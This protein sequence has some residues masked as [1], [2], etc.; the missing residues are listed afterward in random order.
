MLITI[1]RTNFPLVVVEDAGVEVHLL[2]VTKIQFQDFVEAPTLV[3]QERYQEML[4]L[5]PE[6][7]A[8]TFT[9]NNREQLFATGVLP[10]E[11]LAFARWLGQGFDLPT[12]QEWRDILAALRRVPPPRHNL[13]VD[14]V[15]GPAHTILARLKEQMHIRSMADFSLMRGGLVEWVRRTDQLVGLGVPRP[16]FHPNLWDPLVNE[17]KPIHLE[18]RVR[19]FGFRLVRRGDWYLTN[20]EKARYVF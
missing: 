17:I 18:E 3:N 19:Y 14:M 2:P 8:A 11:A 16:Q 4:A 9:A 10:E 15:E 1:D 5:N 12:T 6:V 7:S 13:L 20:K